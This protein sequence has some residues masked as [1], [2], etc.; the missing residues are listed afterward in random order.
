MSP[1]IRTRPPKANR[2]EPAAC[3]FRRYR[4]HNLVEHLFHQLKQSPRIATQ[5]DKSAVSFLGF[6]SLA[7]ARLW[8][9]DLFNRVRVLLMP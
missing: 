3:D 7:A 9:N 4:D 6:L 5:Y 2:R 8:L 1:P